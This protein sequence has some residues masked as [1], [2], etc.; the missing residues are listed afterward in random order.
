MR[1]EALRCIAAVNSNNNGEIFHS[2]DTRPSPSFLVSALF[3]F[4]SHFFPLRCT[5][6]SGLTSNFSRIPHLYF[7]LLSSSVYSPIPPPCTLPILL[8]PPEWIAQVQP[9]PHRVSFNCQPRTRTCVKA[10]KTRAPHTL[11]TGSDK[12][13]PVRI[14]LACVCV[15]LRDQVCVYE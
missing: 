13:G 2:T 9:L 3:F 8:L 14:S 6:S 15:V 4:L 7:P 11:E 1:Q 5:L 10:P 12:P